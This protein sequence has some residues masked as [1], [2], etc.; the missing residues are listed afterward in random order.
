MGWVRSP[1]HEN[2]PPRRNAEHR[3]AQALRAAPPVGG[4]ASTAPR[5]AP[6]GLVVEVGAQEVPPRRVASRERGPRRRHH[7]LP[8]LHP[9]RL[10]VPQVSDARGRGG[11]VV[12]VQ[13]DKNA[14]RRAPVDHRVEHLPR[15]LAFDAWVDIEIDAVGG[16]DGVQAQGELGRDGEADRVEFVLRAD[17]QQVV[18][19]HRPQAVQAVDGGLKA[20][21]VDAWGGRGGGVGGKA[22]RGGPPSSPPARSTP[23]PFR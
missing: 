13:K 7:L 8:S 2:Q 12:H 3:R 10:V 14:A 16:E 23:P 5:G 1:F 17:A 19:R 4:R 21:N 18:D 22:G 15:R 9:V 6:V 11:D 20:E